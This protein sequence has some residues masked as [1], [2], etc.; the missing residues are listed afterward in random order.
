M[1]D[2]PRSVYLVGALLIIISVITL[3]TIT[4]FSQSQTTEVPG[5]QRANPSPTP[6]PSPTPTPVNWSTDPMLRRFVFRSIG[7]A[8]MGGRVDDIAGVDSNPYVV[9]IGFATGGV[10]KSTNN[11][12]TF[13]PIFDTYSTASIGDIAIAPSDPNVVWVGTGEANNR[14]SSSFGDG[15][16]KSTDA[17]KSFT[18]MG[19]E[20]TQTIA[21]IVID[22]KN[23]NIVYVAVLG[24]LFGS[25]KERGV[26]KT[27]DGGNTW[28]NVKFIDED[29][30]FTDLVIDPSD[31]KTL[32]AASYQR[33][34]T[35]FGFNGGGPGSGIWKT[36]DA[37][38]TW[39]KLEGGGLP[40]GVLGRIGVDI[41]R[42]HSNVLYAQIEVGASV[43]TGG[44]EQTSGGQAAPSPSPSPTASASPSA[45]PGAS[46]TPAPLD[47]KKPGV[48]RSDDKGKTWRVVSNE[49]N[50]PMYYS[51]IRVD[52]KNPDIVYV[53]GLNFSKSTDGGK[54]FK[55]LQSGIAHSDNHAIWINPN[56]T[57]QIWVGNDGGLNVTY[58][59]GTTWE[60][61][62]T[63]PAAQLYAVAVDMRKPYYVYG[64][65]Q[66]NGSWG[67]PSQTRSVQGGITNADWYRVGGGDGFY[68]Q[69]D[70]T[71]HNVIYSESQNGAMNRLDMRTG[72]SVSI[73]PRGVPSRRVP[74]RGGP[75]GAAATASPSPGASP[76]PSPEPTTDPTLA[77]FAASQ[78]MGF[79]G[80]NLQSNV[81]PTPAANEQY[82]F[83]WNTPLVMSPHNPRV[84]YVGG[85]RFFKSLDRGDTWT[86]SA[87]LTKHIDRNTLSIMGVPG[88]DPMASKND[89]YTGYG[90]IV[91]IAESAKMPGVI[92]VGTDDGNVQLS[93]DGGSTWTNVAKNIPGIGDTYH[94]S[95][96]EPSHY[97]AGT[98]YVAV[99][100]HRSDDLK[101]YLFVTRDYGTTW[102]SIV[103]NLPSW[104]TVNVITEDPKSKDLLFVGT[105]FGL[106]VSFN[107]GGEWKPMMSGMPTVRIDDI[108]VHPRDGDLIVG[109]H[110]RG[111]YILD[112]ITPLQQL[113]A[114]KVLDKSVHLFDVRSG[115]IWMN[116]TRLGRYVGGSKLFRGQNPAPGTAITYYLKSA[117]AADVKITISDYSG[118]VVR[119][120]VGTNEVGLNRVQ[121]NLRGDP[122]PPRPVGGGFGGGGG[123]GAGGGGGGGGFGG[124]NQGLPL[125]A[126]TYVVKVSVAGTN[127]TTKVVVENDPGL[128]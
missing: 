54:T 125:E 27:T 39:K 116:D 67:G 2:R 47:P 31:S 93:R 60:F 69:I 87:D 73:R 50:R 11:G 121:W 10:W 34:R 59:Q 97:D 7:P 85:D 19:L 35:S 56:N 77:A 6:S 65:L 4:V 90:Y 57:D 53:G 16:Y 24:H 40:E 127:L 95:R 102:S 66:D 12:T 55:S 70:P 110:G 20:N 124:L 106:F 45:T 76:A 94:I 33:R 108:L 51:Q 78:G 100:G 25:N 123:G 113:T 37:G 9:Y 111:I 58:D 17:G 38:K 104:G 75:G 49:N 26:Y 23:A 103:N 118:K 21:R 109:T 89:G 96:V 126:G 117:P 114:S 61:V 8:S 99:D 63:I 32:Y 1:K 101:P 46:P 30:G 28:A 105:E 74:G 84:L 44:E 43:G 128:N 120:L 68:A 79:A 81:V 3:A 22:P 98:C 88:K 5:Q 92:W 72:R 42:S 82:R 80:G 91:T 48:W 36:V 14:Q 15:I 115:T 13:Q 119:N 86:A 41:S 18:K 52:P 71:D 64:G 83:Y 122:P 107:G 29:T 112:D 62:N